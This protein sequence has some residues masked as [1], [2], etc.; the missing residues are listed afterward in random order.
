M[1]AQPEALRLADWLNAH[2]NGPIAAQHQAA[3]ELRGLYA[4]VQTQFQALKAAR[5][6]V[7]ACYQSAKKDETLLRQA[8]AVID[9][10]E[11][12]HGNLWQVPYEPEQLDA[13]ATALRERLK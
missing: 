11:Q 5:Q 7:E 10:M 1:S 3:A 9:S 12:N 2:A 6:L 13:I 4:E 8:L